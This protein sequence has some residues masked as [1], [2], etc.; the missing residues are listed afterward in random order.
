MSNESKELTY[1]EYTVSHNV[2]LDGINLST[3]IAL[4]LFKKQGKS[5]QDFWNVLT[6]DI[7]IKDDFLKEIINLVK[8]DIEKM[9]ETL[10][11]ITVEEILSNQNAEQRFYLMSQIDQADLEKISEVIDEQTITKKQQKTLI[12]GYVEGHKPKFVDSESVKVVDV[13]YK[14]TYT[15]LKIEKSILNA[16]EDVYMVKCKDTS[17]DRVYYLYVD[18]AN[19]AKV[20]KD[21]ISAIASTMEN[22]DGTVFT[23]EQYLELHAEA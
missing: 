2:T 14:D 1:D 13:T 8:G 4:K 20:R 10:S 19:D 3:E 12:N 21:A 15:L 23:K 6:K 7:D 17:T 5:V 18:G 16:P 22:P 9:W 11:P